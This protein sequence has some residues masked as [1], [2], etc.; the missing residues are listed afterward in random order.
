MDTV[1]PDMTALE[2]MLRQAG[3]E[4]KP[5]SDR[6]QQ[7]DVNWSVEA[8]T[9]IDIGESLAKTW[10]DMG[11]QALMVGQKRR[12]DYF[13]VA[14]KVRQKMKIEA[15]EIMEHEAVQKRWLKED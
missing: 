4:V 10:E 6:S 9:L 14:E 13:S 11:E 12:K 2:V 3:A 1:S 8:K 5:S 15:Q 7:A